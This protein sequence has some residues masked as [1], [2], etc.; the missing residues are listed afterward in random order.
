MITRRVGIRLACAI[1]PSVAVV[2]GASQVGV[3]AAFPTKPVRVIVPQ[4][5]GSSADFFAR[6]VGEML[7]EKWKVPVVIDNRPGAG[8]SIAMESLARANADGYT[9]TVTTEGSVAILPHLYSKLKYDTMTDLAPVT[10]VAAAPYILVV[11][12][13]LQAKSVKELIAYAKANPGEINFGSGGNGTGTHLSGE[14][15]RIMSRTDM[16]HV[17]YKGASLAL[18]DV[19]GGQVHMMFVGLPPA[20]GHIKAGKLRAL[21]VTTRKRNF[22]VPDVPTVAESGLPGYEVEPWWGVLVPAQTPADIVRKLNADISEVVRSAGYKQRLASQGA[23]P[24]ADTATE[25]RKVIKTEYDKWG[26]V[27]RSAGVKV[28]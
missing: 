7:S 24:V 25:F 22:L 13:S 12:P 8:G 20:V 19:I 6:L 5:A 10:R 28:Q 23:E 2:F 4:T 27:I 16:V 14:L 17:P 11:N 21:G 15:F 3:A 1:L 18:T 26:K 9:I